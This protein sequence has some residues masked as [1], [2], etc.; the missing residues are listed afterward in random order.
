[1]TRN[2]GLLW[3]AY[4][5]FS[6]ETFALYY[7]LAGTMLSTSLFFLVAGLIVAALAFMAWLLHERGQRL[8]AAA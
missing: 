8:E 4:I 2:R 3:F 1:M 5:A 6:I 7:N